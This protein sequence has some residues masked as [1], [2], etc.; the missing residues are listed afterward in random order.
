VDDRP[1]R[2][3]GDCSDRL[4]VVSGGLD[5]TAR[6]SGPGRRTAAQVGRL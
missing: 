6:R 5:T 1:G 4:S 3:Y 2:A